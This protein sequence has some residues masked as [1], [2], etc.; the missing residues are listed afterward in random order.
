MTQTRTGGCQCGAAR[1]EIRGPELD[2]YACHC[3]ECRK[4]SA[5]AFGISMIVRADDF[6]LTQGAPRCWSRP[7]DSGR[8]LDCWFCPSCG[9][10][11]WH[12]GS[13]DRSILSV[14]GGSLDAPIDF[15]RARHIWTASKLPGLT[16][17]DGA[18]QWP[19][20]PPDRP[21][22]TKG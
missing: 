19:G 21:Y 22:E 11:L 20:E 8:T 15:G 6:S 18:E 7:T 16:L 14:K 13:G 17:P 9:T 4:Q 2:L 5:S 10:R 3:T 12:S 1:Y